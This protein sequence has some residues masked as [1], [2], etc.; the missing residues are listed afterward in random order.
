MKL[1]HLCGRSLCLV[2]VEEGGF[3]PRVRAV[4]ACWWHP[5]AGVPSPEWRRWLLFLW[6]LATMMNEGRTSPYA[7]GAGLASNDR[8]LGIFGC[9]V[10]AYVALVLPCQPLLPLGH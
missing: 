3:G 8:T 4:I 10:W 7:V 2:G 6:L 9:P 1:S 5:F